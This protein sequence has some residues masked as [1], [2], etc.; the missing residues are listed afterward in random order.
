MTRARHPVIHERA[1]DELSGVGTVDH[2]FQQSF[3]DALRDRAMKLP[4]ES[5][6]IDDNSD[7]VDRAKTQQFDPAGFQLDFDLADHA[8]V[9][10]IVGSRMRAGAVESNAE[11]LR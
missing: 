9:G 4:L 3:A 8:A 11:L 7:I 6:R 5:Q 2:L 1:G 10:E